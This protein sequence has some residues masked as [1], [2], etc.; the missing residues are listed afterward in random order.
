MLSPG[1]A[2]IIE[3]SHYVARATGVENCVRTLSYQNIIEQYEIKDSLLGKIG[4]EKLCS[5]RIS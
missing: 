1:F 2:G 5:N 3:N 4:V